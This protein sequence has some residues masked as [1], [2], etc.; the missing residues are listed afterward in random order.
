MYHQTWD[1]L[2]VAPPQARAALQASLA[3]SETLLAR[4]LSL[5]VLFTL[6]MTL[7]LRSRTRDPGFHK[8]MIFLATA[9]AVPAGT[10]RMPWLPSTI[11][12]SY[13]S[14]DLYS[15]VVIAPLFTWDVLRN[16]RIHRAYWIW[17]V[18]CLPFVAFTH[19][20]FRSP[21]WRAIA[22]QILGA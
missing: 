9:L 18:A 13:T 5:G 21:E 7:A 1:A 3:R 17:L 2:Q 4:Q 15:L 14:V 19:A 11:P 6:C 8:R 16:R 10:S 20:T 12:E 22:R